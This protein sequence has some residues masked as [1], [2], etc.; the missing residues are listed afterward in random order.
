MKKA[1]VIAIFS[2]VSAN[3]FAAAL[4]AKPEAFVNCK[5]WSYQPATKTWVSGPNATVKVGECTRTWDE[6]VFGNHTI[7]ACGKYDVTD[8]L[9]SKCRA[10]R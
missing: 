6:V 8:I 2:L 7:K 10:K 5:D 3:G 9:D 4:P 1:I